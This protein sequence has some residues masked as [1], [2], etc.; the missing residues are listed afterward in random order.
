ME[1]G[2]RKFKSIMNKVRK[3]NLKNDSPRKKGCKRNNNGKIMKKQ[4]KNNE[5]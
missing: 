2:N 1:R 3:E 5:D 4:N